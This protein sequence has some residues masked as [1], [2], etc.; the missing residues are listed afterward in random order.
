MS[1]PYISQILQEYASRRSQ[2]EQKAQE[3]R[4]E[5]YLRIPRIREIDR[6]LTKTGLKAMQVSGQTKEH[7]KAGIE[8]LKQSNH[9]LLEEKKTLMVQAGYPED[10]DKPHYTCPYCHD[11]GFVGD[12]RCRCLTQR[13][14]DL[15]YDQSGIRAQLEKENFHTFNLSVFSTRVFPP[16][17]VSPRTNMRNISAR[18]VEYVTAFPD[19]DPRHLLFYGPP[20]TGKTF[21]CNCVAKGVLDKGNSVLYFSASSLFERLDDLRFRRDSAPENNTLKQ[22]LRQC[23]LLILDDLGTEFMSQSSAADLFELVNDRILAGKPMIISTNLYTQFLKQYYSD[24]LY[25]RFNG[26]FEMIEVFGNDLRDPAARKS[27]IK[28]PADI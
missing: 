19:N 4:Q 20:G 25:S 14:I 3:R 26:C 10:Y 16:H 9:A 8:A 21:L 15:H 12:R 24:R 28:K 18:L 17:K 5:L 13:L 6:E 2:A 11:T 23:D 7:R 22:D 1:D 27:V